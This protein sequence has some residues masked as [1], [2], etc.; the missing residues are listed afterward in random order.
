[1]S[2]RQLRRLIYKYEKLVLRYTERACNWAAEE[3]G[4]LARVCAASARAAQSQADRLKAELD[5]LD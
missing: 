3:N 5:D 4:D 2:E 1:M